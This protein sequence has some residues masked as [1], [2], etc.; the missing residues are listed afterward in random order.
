[1]SSTTSDRIRGD[2]SANDNACRVA[3]ELNETPRTV[4]VSLAS[5]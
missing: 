2:T 5:M 3:F 4:N 1:M